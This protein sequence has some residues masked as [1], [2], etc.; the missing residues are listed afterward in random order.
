M[1][2]LKV[3]TDFAEELELLG[4]M[5]V[6]RLFKAMLKYAESGEV[7]DLRG[8]EKFVWPTAKKNIDRTREE[9]QKRKDSVA[10]ALLNK[11][12]QKATKGN[13]AQQEPTIKE[14]DK[15]KEN[16]NNPP[17]P[18]TGVMDER[19]EQ[20]WSAYPKKVGKGAAKAAFMKIKPSQDL[21]DRMVEAVRVASKS[22]QWQKEKGQYI[23][24]PSTWLNQGRWE[25]HME[26]E[27]PKPKEAPYPHPPKLTKEEKL[28]A[29][30][31][32]E[33]RMRNHLLDDLER[34]LCA[35]SIVGT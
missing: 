3:Y 4:D 23:P 25:D 28:E 22:I 6:G 31:M 12:Q 21:T 33:G 1:K 16:I 17:T 10:V 8:N 29:R 13:K 24:N 27:P 35:K 9:S 7:T 2:Y 19:F 18:L 15:D 32:A 26:V 30:Q 20:F 14:K 5:E 11:S 34:K